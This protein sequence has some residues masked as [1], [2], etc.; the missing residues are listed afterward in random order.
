MEID[1]IEIPAGEFIIGLNDE[2]LESLLSQLPAR[3]A[4]REARLIQRESPERTV[5]LDTFYI[6][7]YPITW[8]QYR[9]FALSTHHY[10]HCNTFASEQLQMVLTNLERRV[11]SQ[12]DH[13]ADANWHYA[14]AFCDWIGARLPTSA[15]WEKAARGVDGRLY[16]WGNNWDPARGNFHLDQRRWPLKTSPV[17]AFPTGQSPYGV[18][19]M[20]GNTYEWTCSTAF[21]VASPLGAEEQVICRSCSCDF[22]PGVDTPDSYR[23]RATAIM[24][25]SMNFG[26]ASLVGFRPVLD[27][28]LKRYWAGV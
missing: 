18:M 27:R 17:T 26:G 25:N 23:T 3:F 5:R 28:W 21:G 19:D 4:T 11:E 9:K 10:S 1:W 2:R 20:A 14:L 24:L 12:S 13:P 8:Q 15:E 22:E 7:Q 16:P 6:S